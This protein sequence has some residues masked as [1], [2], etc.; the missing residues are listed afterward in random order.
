MVL[1]KWFHH[2]QVTAFKSRIT[3]SY[4]QTL[5]IKVIWK[6]EKKLAIAN[7]CRAYLHLNGFLSDSENDKVF[8]K[9]RKW[10]DKN[11][12]KIT[13]AQLDSTDFIYNDDAK[14]DDHK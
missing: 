10:Q 6:T 5:K 1:F 3:H 4:F 2:A 8:N 9:I 11:K 7:L 14:D 12:V 13:N